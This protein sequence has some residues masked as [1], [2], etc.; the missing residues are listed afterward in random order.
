MT[1][2]VHR[3]SPNDLSPLKADLVS[4]YREAFQA[5]PYEKSR[6][7]IDEFMHFLPIHAAQPGFRLLLAIESETQ[8][9]IGFTYGRSVTARLPWN[10]LVKPSLRSADLS[11]WL[12][13]AYQV[14]EMAV[15]PEAQGQGVGSQLHDRLLKDLSHRRAVLST[16]TAET[17]ASRLYLRKGW[18]VLVDELVVPDV[19]R[20]YCVMGLDLPYVPVDAA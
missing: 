10:D 13:D 4:I 6:A 2:K 16:M 5:P 8:K 19:P 3:T 18:K 15:H 12:K 20:P 7:E 14:V 9:V 17:P 11:K 1:Y